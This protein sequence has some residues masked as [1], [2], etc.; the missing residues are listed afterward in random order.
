MI[1]SSLSPISVTSVVRSSSPH[2]ESRLLTRV[3]SCVVPKSIDACHLHQAGAGG[4]LVGHRDRVLEVAEDDVDGGHDLGQ[5]GDDLVVLRREEVDDPAGAEGDLADRLRGTDGERLEEVTGA[6]H[7]VRL[8]SRSI[9]VQCCMPGWMDGVDA[10]LFDA[11]GILV[12]PDPTVL[13]PLLAY[14]GGDAS[15]EAP[16]ASPLRGR[17]R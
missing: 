17:W 10:I 13:G 2:G 16:P 8:G 11:G 5:L 14:Y 4:L 7:I 12:L 15:I 1:T 6:A 3:Q 9:A